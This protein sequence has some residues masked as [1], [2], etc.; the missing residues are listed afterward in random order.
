METWCLAH[1]T[2]GGAAAGDNLR[3]GAR[4][5]KIRG[6]LPMADVVDDA[7][8]REAGTKAKID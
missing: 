6:R 1:P 5:R 8:H 7:D 3:H 4:T 2:L